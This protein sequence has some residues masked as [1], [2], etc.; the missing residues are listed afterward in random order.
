M[1]DFLLDNFLDTAAA[2]LETDIEL[3]FPGKHVHRH[4]RL[5]PYLPNISDAEL[6]LYFDSKEQAQRLFS[7]QEDLVAAFMR[8]QVRSNGHIIWVFQAF[9]ALA[10]TRHRSKIPARAAPEI[11]QSTSRRSPFSVASAALSPW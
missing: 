6:V 8:G 10:N 1:R 11:L 3:R 9:A 5:H 2:A 7:G 4:P